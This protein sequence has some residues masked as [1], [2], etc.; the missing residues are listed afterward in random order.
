[1]NNGNLEKNKKE[2]TITLVPKTNKKDKK[3]SDTNL[4]KHMIYMLK[5]IK[6][7]DERDQRGP[8]LMQKYTILTD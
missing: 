8:K 4:T 2:C 3:Y 7:T 1:M 5:T 6:Y